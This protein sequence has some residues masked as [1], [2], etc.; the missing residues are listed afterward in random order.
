MLNLFKYFAVAIVAAIVNI[1]MLY[2][3]TDVCGINYL[4]SNIFAFS[5]GLFTNYILCKKYVFKNSNLNKPVEFLIYAII[6][7][8][9]LCIDT[10]FLF[11]FTSK[12]KIY[13]MLSKI[14]STVITFFWNYFARKVFYSIIN[15][16][17]L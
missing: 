8:I 17:K 5:L 13:Y 12:L 15:K 9:G 4:I 3:F 14:I 6:G 2:F 11:F 10:F 16:E 1:G 7:V